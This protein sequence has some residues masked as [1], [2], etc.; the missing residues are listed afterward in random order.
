MPLQATVRTVSND[1]ARPAQFT[2]L[3]AA[4]DVSSPGDTLRIA[5][6]STSYAGVTLLF[7]LTMI[8]EGANNPNG[9]ST[10]I[11]LINLGRLNSSLGSSGSKFYGIRFLLFDH[12][13]INPAF[14]GGTLNTQT[15]D[16]IIFERCQFNQYFSNSFALNGSSAQINNLLFRNCV[17]HVPSMNFSGSNFTSITFTNCIFGTNNQIIGSTSIL[18]GG[19]L[20]RNCLFLNST[21]PRFSNISGVIVENSIFYKSEPTGL[22]NSVFNNNITYLCNSNTIPYG[23]NA[24]SGNLIKCK[25]FIH[26][27]SPLGS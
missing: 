24:G 25:S 19:L 1:P 26:K 21:T 27:L 5:G 3:S 2:T 7:P 23:T 18:N 20:L 16:N 11:A 8:G 4:I 13:N 17:F 12:M 10:Q 6:S 22:N 9:Q 15:L 14:T